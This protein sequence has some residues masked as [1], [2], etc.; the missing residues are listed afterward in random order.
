MDT[1][2]SCVYYILSLSSTNSITSAAHFAS[3]ASKILFN[4]Q[5]S[6][7]KSLPQKTSQFFERLSYYCLHSKSS[8]STQS[9]LLLW[10]VTC[11]LFSSHKFNPA[12]ICLNYAEDFPK[13]PKE[14]S[15]KQQQQKSKKQEELL[16]SRSVLPGGT[17]S[18]CLPC[19]RPHSA[20]ESAHA[21]RPRDGFHPPVGEEAL[22][23]EMATYLSYS[24]LK[25]P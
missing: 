3:I 25:I 5:I 18:T 11:L 1:C 6:T 19:R 23:E 13:A 16:F 14:I 20:E 2:A 10:I 9:S 12:L 7:H 4:D 24:C 22:E 21:G 15:V 17:V 8:Y